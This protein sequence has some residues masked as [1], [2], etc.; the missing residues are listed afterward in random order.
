MVD[1]HEDDDRDP[2]PMQVVKKQREVKE[3]VSEEVYNSGL[4]SS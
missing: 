4:Y 3:I 2:G 1:E